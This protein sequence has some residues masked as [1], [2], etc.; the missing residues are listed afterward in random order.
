M[1]SALPRFWGIWSSCSLAVW[2]K[3]KTHTKQVYIVTLFKWIK[4]VVAALSLA[5][6]KLLCSYPCVNA[7]WD[8]VL[9]YTQ[10]D[11]VTLGSTNEKN[12]LSTFCIPATK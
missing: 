5:Q 9:I 6:E 1:A 3:Y 7:T 12:I 2:Q 8:G 11:K 4:H 10:E